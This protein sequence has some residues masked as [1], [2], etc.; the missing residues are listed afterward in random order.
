M[1]ERVQ[2]IRIEDGLRASFTISEASNPST[3]SPSS[4]VSSSPQFVAGHP[5]TIGHPLS[6]AAI[7][8]RIPVPNVDGYHDLPLDP[9]CCLM[10]QTSMFH[11]TPHLI[12]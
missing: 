9:L 7:P 1:I 2:V 6:P 10:S 12:L 3:P 5:L 8:Y 4:R 11:Q